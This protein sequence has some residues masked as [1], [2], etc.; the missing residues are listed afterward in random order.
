MSSFLQGDQLYAQVTVSEIGEINFSWCSYTARLV[1]YTIK[2]VF[3]PLVMK[4]WHCN[5]PRNLS[6]ILLL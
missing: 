6:D 1:K 2:R 5:I 3:R 4:Y